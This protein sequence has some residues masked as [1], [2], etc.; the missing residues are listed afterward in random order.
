MSVFFP[1][2][3][4]ADVRAATRNPGT[5]F[6]AVINSSVMPSPKYSFSCCPLAFSKGSTAIERS[7]EGGRAVRR[8]AMARPAA[9][10]SAAAATTMAAR[11]KK[12]PDGAAER[13]ESSACSTSP[14]E[15]GRLAGSFSSRRMMSAASAGGTS[16]RHSFSGLGTSMTCAMINCCGDRPA[17]SPLPQ[18]ISYATAPRA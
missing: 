13:P 9:A 5:L 4:K 1:L 3:A 7:C 10:S 2:K 11:L 6:R 8:E 16:G 15:A 18:S 14:A 12:P 17:N